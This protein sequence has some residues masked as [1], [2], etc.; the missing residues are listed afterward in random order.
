M[1]PVRTMFVAASLMFIFMFGMIY[2]IG[3]FETGNGLPLNATIATNF[4]AIGLNPSS[5]NGGVFSGFG[6]YS[7]GIYTTANSLQTF[8]SNPIA[9]ALST[10][11]LVGSFIF[12]IPS[13]F[14]LMGAF[15][16]VPLAAIG[17]PIGFAQM[18]GTI[19]LIGVFALG[20]ISAVFL[21][22]I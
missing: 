3:S 5:P 20:L 13:L 2:F 10:V 7:S 11:S 17:I 22:P 16:A 8:N 12:S 9:S 15:I 21:F 4:N 6:N 14:R 18:I 1:P 19:T